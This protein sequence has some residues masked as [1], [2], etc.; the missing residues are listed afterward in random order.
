MNN[1]PSLYLA[2]GS[3]R[4]RELLHGL[5]FEL[6]RLSA[7][8]DETPNLNEAADAYVLRMARQKNA[9]ALAQWQ[10]QH[11]GAPA[12][13]VLSADTTVAL[14]NHILGKPENAAEARAMLRQLS[15]NTHQV[16]TAV[17]V[18]VAGQC[19]DVLQSSDVRF[20]TLSAAEIEA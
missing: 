4:R 14:G 7:D 5:G 10:A 13:P 15:G 2:S 12:Y 20:K 9:V 18:S 11:S 16:L 19:F 17:C 1:K 6:I 8:I 3:P